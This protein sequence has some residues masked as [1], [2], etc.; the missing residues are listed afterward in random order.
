MG[1]YDDMQ[2]VASEL[3]AEFQ[4]GTVQL[5]RITVT[6]GEN[7]WEEGT[8]VE[9]IWTLKAA[10]KRLHQRYEN[11][12]LIVET[13]DMLTIATKGTLTKLN[14]AA[15]SPVEQDIEPLNS[16]ILVIDGQDRAID[17][18]TPIPGAGIAAAWKVWSKA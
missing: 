5:K 15:V 4:Q 14:G 13:G 9:T 10:V 17:N 2:A 11:G 8:E 1:F 3:L 12:A 6:P 7:A 18:V 16:D